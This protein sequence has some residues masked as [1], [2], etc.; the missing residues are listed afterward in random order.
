MIRHAWSVLCEKVLTDRD[1]NNVSLD[2]LEQLSVAGAPPPSGERPLLPVRIE[3]VSLW[4]RAEAGESSA[5]SGEAV[6]RLLSPVGDELA[7]L[8]MKVDLGTRPRAR[9]RALL[10]GIPFTG[11]GQ[12]LF[13]VSLAG[14]EVARLPLQVGMQPSQATPA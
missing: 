1:T 8:A 6:L 13:T 3:L 4:Y 11:P 14:E 9:T 7:D 12:Y 10:P 5:L 2:V